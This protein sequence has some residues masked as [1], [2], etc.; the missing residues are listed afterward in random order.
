MVSCPLKSRLKKAG[1]FY[2]TKS[3]PNVDVEMHEMP[4]MPEMPE[5]PEMHEELFDEMEPVPKHQWFHKEMEDYYKMEYGGRYGWCTSQK[6]AK[7]RW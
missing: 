3:M 1:L 5:T 4:E 2:S 7:T 6:I